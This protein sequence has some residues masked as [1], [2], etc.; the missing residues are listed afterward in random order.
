MLDYRFT[1]VIPLLMVTF[2]RFFSTHSMF[3]QF[4]NIL[5]EGKNM[6]EDIQLE[7]R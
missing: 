5:P 3:Y 6:R 2:L 7:E 1:P 4:V